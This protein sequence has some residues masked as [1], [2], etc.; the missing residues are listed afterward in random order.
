MPSFYYLPLKIDDKYIIIEGDEFNHIAKSLRNSIGDIISI[1]N[2]QG[3]KATAQIEKIESNRLVA[4]IQEKNIFERSIPRIALA[5]SVLKNKRTEIIIEKCTELGVHQFF[6]FISERTVKKNY[7][8]Q[9]VKRWQKIAISSMKQCDSAF[10]PHIENIKNFYEQIKSIASVYQLI[11]AWEEEKQSFLYNA[12]P[13]L[14][15]K[16]DICL[17][18]GPEGG[19]T[20]EEIDFVRKLNGKVIC[21]GTN[22]LRAETAAIVILANTIFCLHSDLQL[23]KRKFITKSTNLSRSNI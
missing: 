18:V 13:D 11:I 4:R 9:L 23:I 5:H 10:L 22:V 21:L 1:T 19:F 16:K 8:Q 2:G 14:N 7:S 6:P 20:K 3:I 12:F 17:I 15:K